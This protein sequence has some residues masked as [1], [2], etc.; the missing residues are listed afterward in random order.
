[1]Y[2]VY[3]RVF[4]LRRQ[5]R[6]EA[7][8][9]VA[10]AGRWALAFLVL[11]LLSML[12]GPAFL[13]FL[14]RSPDE[15][16]RGL[17]ELWFRACLL[18]MVVISMD[19]HATV[20][21]GQARDVL[22][23]LPVRPR[24][25]VLA[26]LEQVALQR[27]PW[28][29]ALGVLLWPV[30]QQASVAAWA[31]GM[32]VVT[33]SA[34]LA[35]TWSAVAF[36]GAIDAAESPAAAPL[37]DLLRG[38]NPRPQAALIYAL[39]P[40]TV[41][42]GLLAGRASGSA[43]GIV[44][45]AQAGWLDA[46]VLIAVAAAGWP[47]A[48]RLADRNWFRASMVLEDIRA[49]YA[50]VE[51]PDEALHVYLEWTVRWLPTEAARWALLEL[52]YGWRERRSWIS[53][54]NLI[55]FGGLVLGWSS[56]VEAPV[57]A[58]LVAGA[59]AWLGAGVVVQRA[60]DVPAF[61]RWSMPAPALAGTVARMWA[62][63]AWSLLPLGLAGLAVWMFRGGSGLVQFGALGVL[64]LGVAAPVAA[65]CARHEERGMGLLIAAALI[66]VTSTAWWWAEGIG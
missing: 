66:S 9:T 29:V 5:R 3:R 14:T 52:R 56:T 1:V 60:R 49:R 41:V 65:W 45:G 21:R 36:L 63:V 12:V 30:A 24:G 39:V 33:A 38:N 28:L 22:T 10:L 64:Q 31:L 53:L 8:G 32:L 61:L 44:V 4:A 57:R 51:G 58:G 40:T 50:A 16:V 62:V 25:V 7:E 46:A 13:G 37:L 47:A 59:A 17:G 27:G 54:M 6:R 42:G 26:E 55:G 35:L 18:V 15:V 19:V 20:L 11:G 2:S 48:A 23:L 43:A 34:A